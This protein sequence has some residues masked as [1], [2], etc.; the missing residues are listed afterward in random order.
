ME[1]LFESFQVKHRIKDIRMNTTEMIWTQTKNMDILRQ[2]NW[3]QEAI[4]HLQVSD[5]RQKE[6]KT[7]TIL[8]RIPIL[9]Q[10]SQSG[11]YL[12]EI[13]LAAD[14]AQTNYEKCR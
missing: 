13:C 8:L 4:K 7:L 11:K 14:V 2:D 5:K 12:H 6:K 9:L 3:T 1:F 10:F